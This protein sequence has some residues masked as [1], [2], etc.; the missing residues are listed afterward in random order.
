MQQYTPTSEKSNNSK[1][2][3]IVRIHWLRND[4]PANFAEAAAASEFGPSWAARSARDFVDHP[5]PGAVE[6]GPIL[7]D[8]GARLLDRKRRAA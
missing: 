2:P 7:L 5:P 3:R 6:P 4:K 8:A 1:P